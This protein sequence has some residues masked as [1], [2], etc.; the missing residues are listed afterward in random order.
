MRLTTRHK[1]FDTI[2][3]L[4]LVFSSG[5]LLFAFHRKLFSIILF[6]SS[7]FSLLFM[8]EKIKK[9]VFNT[10][11][12]SLLFFC[13]VICINYICSLGDQ[14]Y[15]KYGFHLLNISSCV[16]I[17]T[18]F[19]NNRDT[20][21]FLKRLRWVLRLI[22]YFSICNFIFYLV[23]KNNLS[24]ITYNTDKV[25]HTFHFIFFYNPER[26]AF[27][28]LG[29]EFVRNQG[30]FWE[31]GINQ[32]YL[33]ILLYLEGLVF[34]RNKWIILLIVLVIFT[35]YSTTGIVI[36]MVTL[37]FI[38]RDSIKKNP[39]LIFLAISIALPLY[40]VAKLNVEEK[41]ET[42]S[43]QKRY[44]DLIQTI[45]II[46]DYPLIG[47]GLDDRYFSEFRS[48][49]FISNN[50][51]N[52]FEES[53]NFELKAKSTDKGSSN[54]ITY[55]IVAMGVPIS[56]FLLFCLFKQTLFPNRQKIIMTIIFISVFT[57]P[58]LLRPFFLILIVSG[59]MSFF[60][61]FTK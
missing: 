42:S 32:I 38:F 53:T 57:E 14:S 37:F 28:I 34:K 15:I 25:L 1:L 12:F 7:I 43:F 3:V 21:Y 29:L 19:I 24:Q 8:G 55:L 48:S 2:L 47:I 33:N 51:L 36:M 20:T 10:S 39:V 23:V 13:I 49:H 16:F 44:F 17:L 58:L 46:N 59:M 31:P 4:F 56:A 30:W 50:I 11:L 54:S 61:R 27:N 9:S 40:F 6:L 5:G 35:T 45:S 26:S 52:S 22:L 60:S 41:L 18:H